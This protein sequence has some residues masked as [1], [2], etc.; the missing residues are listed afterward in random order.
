V[1]PIRRRLWERGQDRPASRRSKRPAELV[2]A[3]VFAIGATMGTRAE[4]RPQVWHFAANENFDASGTFV[5]AR[6]GFNLA[7]VS[8]RR[9]L[10]LLPAG[11]KGLVWVGQ[12]DGVTPKFETVVGALIDH[13]KAFGFYLMDDP[14]PT[15]R[16]R[17]RCR[18]SD[19]RAES[20]WIHRRRPAAVTFVALMNL[21]SSTSPRFSAEYRPEVSH[22]D[23]FGVAPYPCRTG[24]PECDL[25]M[26]DR[27]VRAS[28]IAG[29]PLARIVPTFQSFGGGTWNADSGGAYRLPSS[30]EMQSMLE[31]WDKLAPAPAFDY[32]YSWGQQR[33]DESLAA[34][35]DLRAVFARRNYEAEAPAPRE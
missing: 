3:F 33:F 28:R 2:L 16:W 9:E 34:S 19:L 4:K 22:V 6:A 31:R 11:T 13:P 5:P 21:G 23:L 25:A 35:A 26:I 29:V 27:F 1:N 18:A 10:D 32:A 17:H 15:G 14:D 30:S 20:D 12:C 24:W 7:D 8:S